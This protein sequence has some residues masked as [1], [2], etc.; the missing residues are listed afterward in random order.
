MGDVYNRVCGYI[1]YEDLRRYF[2][3]TILEKYFY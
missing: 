2:S 1:Q 3:C